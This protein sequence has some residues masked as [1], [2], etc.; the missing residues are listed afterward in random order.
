MKVCEASF[1]IVQYIEATVKYIQHL[2]NKLKNALKVER[3]TTPKKAHIPISGRFSSP[4]GGKLPEDESKL[5]AKLRS[6]QDL[7]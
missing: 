1:A 4:F 2:R 6:T 5:A 3:T 7:Q